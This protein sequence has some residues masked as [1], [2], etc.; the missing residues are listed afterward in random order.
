MSPALGSWVTSVSGPLNPGPKPCASR[1]YARFEVKEVGLLPASLF[2]SRSQ[3]AGA[4]SS[5]ISD[6]AAIAAIAG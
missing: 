4:A 3:S 6:V 2:P 5:S 1:S